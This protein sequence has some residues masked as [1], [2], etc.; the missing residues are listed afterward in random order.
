MPLAVEGRWKGA[1]GGFA[2]VSTEPAQGALGVRCLNGLT[3]P[4]RRGQWGESPP[5]IELDTPAPHSDVFGAS[6][7]LLL[8]WGQW[9]MK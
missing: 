9:R 5:G 6:V 3:V 7:H 1:Y 8:V 2:L 4:Q